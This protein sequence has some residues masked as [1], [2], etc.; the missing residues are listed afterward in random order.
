[1]NWLLL[2]VLLVLVCCALGGYR[3]GLVKVLFSLASSILALI[4]VSIFSPFIE[5]LLREHTTMYEF[6][7]EKSSAMVSEWNQNQNVS[8]EEARFAAIEGYEVP[9]FLKNYFKADHTAETLEQ[10]FNGYISG[11]IAD[12]VIDAASF[13]L[14]FLVILL[15]LHIVAQLLSLVTKLPVIRTMNHVGGLAAGA[16]EGLLVVWLFFLALTFLCTTEFGKS[17]M[18]M[19]GN[20]QILGWLYNNN[21]LMRLLI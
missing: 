12:L 19:I 7:Q 2:I 14:S 15:V 9:D 11:K 13:V 20:S 17:C 16:L 21:P 3:K 8:T 10:E 4:L 6:V 1:M 18:Q 5:T